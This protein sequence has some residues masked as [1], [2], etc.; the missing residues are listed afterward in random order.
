MALGNRHDPLTDLKLSIRELKNIAKETNKLSVQE[1]GDSQ[2]PMIENIQTDMPTNETDFLLLEM[3]GKKEIDGEE[4]VK[5][6]DDDKS[7]DT[8]R[9]YTTFKKCGLYF[10]QGDSKHYNKNNSHNTKNN[11]R[12]HE[13]RPFFTFNLKYTDF[14]RFKQ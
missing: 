14:N 12:I 3:T 7:T 2:E 6:A 10:R 9:F 5:D 11:G 4:S 8:F 1:K 13:R